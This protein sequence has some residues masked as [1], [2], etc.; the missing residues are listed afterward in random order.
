ML[1][2]HLEEFLT[3]EFGVRPDV[4]PA[5]E[6]M[7]KEGSA[8]N[9]SRGLEGPLIIDIDC[10]IYQSFVEKDEPSLWYSPQDGHDN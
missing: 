5:E 8:Q 4:A 6:T 3:N 9:F 2:R 10:F 1:F 7:A